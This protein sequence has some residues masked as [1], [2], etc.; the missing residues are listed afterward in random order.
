M[1]IERVGA[2]VSEVETSR[3]NEMNT[4][5]R[6]RGRPYSVHAPRGRGVPQMRAQY[7]ALFSNNGVILRAGGRW[8]QKRPKNCVRTLWTARNQN[9]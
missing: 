9:L 7:I 8:G 3:Y 5:S 6:V 2:K 1:K 4:E